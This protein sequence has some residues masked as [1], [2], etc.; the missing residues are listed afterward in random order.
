MAIENGHRSGRLDARR[1]GEF[2]CSDCNRR[3]TRGPSGTEYGHARGTELGSG[4][5]DCPRRPD[6]VDPTKPDGDRSNGGGVA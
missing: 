3:C 2:I 6:G 1:A 4:R 5:G